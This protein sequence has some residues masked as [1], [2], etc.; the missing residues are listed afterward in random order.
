MTFNRPLV[1]GVLNVT[2]DSFSD[3]GEYTSVESA[4]DHARLLIMGG[5][6]IID[7]GGESTRPGAARVSPEIELA[8]VIPVIEAIVEELQKIDRRDVLISIDTMN[9]STALAS[10]AAGASIINDVS[11]GLADEK[12][13]GLAAASGAKIIISH[14]RGFSDEM[15][16]NAQYI[17]VAREVA[18]EL[19]AR[20]DA[21]I[22]AGVKRSKI[23]ID[24]GLGFAK[25]MQQNWQLVARLDELEKLDLP[26]LV[27]ASRKR[28]IAGA[29]EPGLEPEV[30][31]ISNNRRDL[32]TA[33]LTAL[34]LQRKIWGVRVHNVIAT[35]DAI[36]VVEA[37][38][39]GSEEGQS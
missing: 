33:V 16:N 35:S 30:T 28:F 2:P 24:P 1:M 39:Q 9:A 37:L 13:F 20:V 10:V 14:W 5:A 18:I 29:L 8:R 11:G 4:L 12:M 34:L 19:Q 7:I 21:A 38:R 32:A 17:D 23:I 36:S 27:G 6:N 22:A 26:I 15:Q 3:G 31:E 25:D